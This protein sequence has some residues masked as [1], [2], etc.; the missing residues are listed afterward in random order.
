[1]CVIVWVKYLLVESQLLV[2][3]WV[4]GF[5]RIIREEKKSRNQGT[6]VRLPCGTI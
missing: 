5:G 2:T 1:M 3:Q 4:A 6:Y